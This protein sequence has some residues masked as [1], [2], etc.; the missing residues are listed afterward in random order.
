[1]TTPG[2][3]SDAQPE[4]AS[5]GLAHGFTASGQRMASPVTTFASLKIRNFRLLAAGRLVSTTGVWMQRIAQDWLILNITH[6]ATAVG[7][8]TGLQC[9]PTLLLGVVGG[10]VGDRFPKRRVLLTTQF[11]LASLAGALAVLALVHEAAPWNVYLIAFLLGV[12]SVVDNPTGQSFVVELVGPDY[13]RN[14]ISINS[15]V[16]QLGGFVGPALAGI[17]I[18]ALGVGYAFALNALSYLGPIVALA[19]IRERELVAPAAR[20]HVRQPPLPLRRVVSHPEVSTSLIMAATLGLFAPNLPVTL[21]ALAR[22]DLKGGAGLYGVLNA[23][24]AAGSVIGALYSA[25]QSAP[26]LGTFLGFGG[27]VAVGYLLAAA[28]PDEVTLAAALLGLGGVTLLVM[29][30]ANAMIQLNTP[31][32]VQGRVMGLFLLV[33]LGAATVGGPLVGLM[34]QS[35][36]PRSGLVV[37][38]IVPGITAATLFLRSRGWPSVTARRGRESAGEGADS[39]A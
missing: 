33:V 38:G 22:V 2:K 14:A 6:N 4:S 34:D 5:L 7:L 17:T 23:V 25:R 27:L 32:V 35:F 29:T 31:R 9:L 18:N 12:V 36:G 28:A 11:M 39:S 19:L 30:S 37:A 24:V 15:S 3:P 20:T 10:G 21:A 26:R 8:A 16:F 1:M 13:L